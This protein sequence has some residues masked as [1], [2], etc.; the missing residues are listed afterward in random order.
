MNIIR[1]SAMAALGFA[2]QSGN[3]LAQQ[4][5][6]IP[7]LQSQSLPPPSGSQTVQPIVVPT[8][9]VLPSASAFTSC[10]INCDTRAMNCQSLCVPVTG[11]AAA[12]PAGA[13]S[14]CNLGCATQQ[15]VCKQSC[16][17]GQ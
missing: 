6:S 5:T 15:L 1:L 7:P 2:L 17:L 10:T 14:S 4:P 9:Q 16:G 3:A 8:P 11:A 13:T 12:A